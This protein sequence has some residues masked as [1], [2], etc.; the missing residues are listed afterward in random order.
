MYNPTFELLYAINH[1]IYLFAL[2]DSLNYVYFFVSVLSK[3]TNCI[4]TVSILYFTE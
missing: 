2:S 1:F 3:A 4:N